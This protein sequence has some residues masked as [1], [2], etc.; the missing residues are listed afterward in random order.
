MKIFEN[1]ILFLNENNQFKTANTIHLL[2]QNFCL[3][4]SSFS[5]ILENF[6]TNSTY[7][8]STEDFDVFISSS[9]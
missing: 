6:E 2:S 1:F 5:S 7:N 8:N 3:F 4:S 9:P